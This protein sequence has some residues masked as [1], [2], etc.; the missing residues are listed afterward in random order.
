VIA[1]GFLIEKFNLFLLTIAG[2][3]VGDAPHR[4]HELLSR[5]LGRFE[6]LAFIT[7]ATPPNMTRNGALRAHHTVAR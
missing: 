3:A 2:S 4:A 1:F 7:I 5:P 6:G